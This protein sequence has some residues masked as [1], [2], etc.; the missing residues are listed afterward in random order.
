M[1]LLRKILLLLLEFTY[2]QFQWLVVQA[3]LQSKKEIQCWSVQFDKTMEGKKRKFLLLLLK[4]SVPSSDGHQSTP[5][6]AC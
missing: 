1:I 2:R 4:F 5:V 3:C 6:T